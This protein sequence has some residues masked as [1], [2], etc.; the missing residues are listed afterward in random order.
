MSEQPSHTPEGRSLVSEVTDSIDLQAYWR[1][2]VRRR[3]LIIPFFLAVVLVTGVVTL[4]QTR[5]YDATCTI[6]IDLSAPKV[7]DKD[8]VQEVVES[9]SG[10]YWYSKEFY[11]TQYKVLTSRTVAQRVVDKLQLGQ[12]LRFLDLDGEQDPAELA[13][14]DGPGRPGPTLLK[15][16][17][18]AA[19][20]G[21]AHRP[22]HLRGRRPAV[23]RPGGQ[24]PGRVLHRREPLGEDRD[25]PERLG[26]AGDPAR[27]PG[28]EARPLRQG[29]LRLQEEP[30]HRRHHLGGPPVDGHPAAHPDQ[31]AR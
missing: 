6:I 12:N 3:W 22:A 20:E 24:H 17:K 15:N 1:T 7:L 21:L 19:G 10:G 23:R 31:R 27:R 28:E 29:P 4:R 13:A 11:E 16:L 9:G 2:I 5:I 14:A 30:R 18:L 25:H 8:S 26:V